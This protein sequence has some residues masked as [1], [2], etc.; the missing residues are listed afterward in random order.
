MGC[1]A[2]YTAVQIRNTFIQVSVVRPREGMANDSTR[3]IVTL[4][5]GQR[6]MSVHC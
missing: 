2:R 4:C 1:T 3:T 5:A 6:Q